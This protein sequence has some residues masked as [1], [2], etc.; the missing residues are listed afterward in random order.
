MFVRLSV[1]GHTIGGQQ[2]SVHPDVEVEQVGERVVGHQHDG[3]VVHLPVVHNRLPRGL[4]VAL[5]QPHTAALCRRMASRMPFKLDRQGGVQPTEGNGSWKTGGGGD[6]SRLMEG[7]AASQNRV[8][9]VTLT[10]A[11]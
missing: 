2:V 10:V 8:N 1:W 5:A 9:C 7:T 4:G 11:R 3:A 6:R